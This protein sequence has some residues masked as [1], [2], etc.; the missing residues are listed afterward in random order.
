M[1]SFCFYFES[2]SKKRSQNRLPFSLIEIDNVHWTIINGWSDVPI[3]G[4]ILEW[5]WNDI[6]EGNLKTI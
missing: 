4:R 3:G 1:I 5:I 6:G 2:I